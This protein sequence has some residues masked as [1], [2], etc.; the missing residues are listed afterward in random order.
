MQAASSRQATNRQTSCPKKERVMIPSN[1]FCTTR[2]KQLSKQAEPSS[3]AL[4]NFILRA[5]GGERWPDVVAPPQGWDEKVQ[6][7]SCRN[8]HVS[9]TVSF[10]H[11]WLKVCGRA[12]ISMSPSPVTCFIRHPCVP[13]RSLRH[14]RS[15]PHRLRRA[16]PRPKSSGPSAL[17]HERRGVWLPGRSTGYE[18][19]QPGKTTSVDGDTTPINDP[20]HD[21]ISDF[22]RTTRENTEQFGVPLVLETSVSHVSHGDFA[23]QRESQESMPRENRCKTE[24]K[25]GKRR[26]CDQCCRVDVK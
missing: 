8:P 14:Q 17:P 6:T 16:L 12:H 15:R 11:A 1:L 7:H 4:G 25:R 10:A 18:H 5:K 24:R 13:A 3:T 19:K 23:L 20:D 2:T 9:D 22:S 26:F 21:S